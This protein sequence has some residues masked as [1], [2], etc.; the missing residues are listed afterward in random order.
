[1]GLQR[2]AQYCT[3]ASYYLIGTPVACMFLFWGDFGVI[4]FS[5]GYLAAAFAQVVAYLGILWYKSWEEVADAAAERIKAEE[6]RR[7]ALKLAEEQQAEDLLQDGYT[8]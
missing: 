2:I 6:A 8:K 3:I 5:F 4:S 7:A 1:M